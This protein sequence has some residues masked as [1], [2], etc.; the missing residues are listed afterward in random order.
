MRGDRGN[1]IRT[2]TLS[3]QIFNI[4]RE[5]LKGNS[6]MEGYLC[7]VV[8]TV[9]CFVVVALLEPIVFIVTLLCCNVSCFIIELIC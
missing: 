8:C 5:N 7:T 4:L 3:K 2:L 9:G 1:C 6:T